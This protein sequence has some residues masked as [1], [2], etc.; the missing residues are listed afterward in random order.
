MNQKKSLVIWTKKTVF[1]KSLAYAGFFFNGILALSA[2]IMVGDPLSGYLHGI[3]FLIF[4]ITSYF[5][6]KKRV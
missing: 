1:L 4:V 6:D 5:Y 3:L 2:H